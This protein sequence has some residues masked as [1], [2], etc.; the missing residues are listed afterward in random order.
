MTR[1]SRLWELGMAAALGGCAS[2]PVLIQQM[3]L[4]EYTPGGCTAP[5]NPTR[6]R[7]DRGTFD[8]GLRNRYV[9]RPLFRNPLTQ[10]V[11]VR[12]VVMTIREG[13]PDG[14]LVGPTFTAYQTVTLPAADGAPGYLAAEMEMIPAQVGSALRSA[15]CRFEPTT[16]ACPVPRTTSVDRSLLLTITAFGETSSGSEFE[17]PPF[18]FPVRVCCGCLVTFSPESRAP[19]VVHRSPN[20]DQGSASQGP[21]SCALGQ[22]LSVDCRL[23]SG[24]N[25][26]CQPAG[27]ATDPAA[28]ACAP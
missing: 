8:V 9:G 15:V 11:I 21:A 27:Y 24:A 13:S 6:S 17:A 3:Q 28:A 25:P 20:C 18:T 23:C 12:G 14:P 4:P 5:S 1:S 19:E 22:D 16:A 26:Q 10:P 2:D 7:L